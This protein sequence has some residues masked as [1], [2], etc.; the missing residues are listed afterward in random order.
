MD[1]EHLAVTMRASAD[2]NGRNGQPLGD[3][4]GQVQWNT[5]QH[6]RERAAIL[7][8]QRIAHDC[9]PLVLILTLNPIAAEPMNRLRGKA[10]VSHDR[11]ANLDDGLDGTL[12]R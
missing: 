10:N 1:H 11:D 7:Y 5:L 6:N 12:H 2:A 3:L 8:R 9:F 4:L